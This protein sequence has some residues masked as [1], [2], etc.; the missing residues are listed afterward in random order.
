MPYSPRYIDF[1][2]IYYITYW[3]IL[4]QLSCSPQ[5]QN[6]GFYTRFMGKIMDFYPI[7]RLIFHLQHE[8]ESQYGGR[9]ASRGCNKS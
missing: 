5:E 9:G 7:L 2:Q 3:C 8:L 1:A 4:F 6:F